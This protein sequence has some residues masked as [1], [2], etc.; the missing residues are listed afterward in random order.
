MSLIKSMCPVCRRQIMVVAELSGSRV[1]CPGCSEALLVTPSGVRAVSSA[2]KQPTLSTNTVADREKSPSSGMRKPEKFQRVTTDAVTPP[3]IPS[4]PPGMLKLSWILGAGVGA[5]GFLTIAL[6]AGFIL[7]SP[8]PRQ[9][10]GNNVLPILIDIPPTVTTKKPIERPTPTKRKNSL[11]PVKDAI[12]SVAVVETGHGHGSGFMAA[13]GL[14]VTNYHVISMARMEDVRIRFPDNSSVIEREFLAELIAEDPFNDIAVLRVDCEVPPLRIEEK[15]QHV[16]GQKVVA[17][18]SP[19]TGTTD[20]GMLANLTTDGRMG[21]EYPLPNGGIR[22][23]VSMAM[24]PGNSGGP[25]IDASHGE[26]VG[27]TV[28]M[29]TKTNSQSLAVPHPELIKI[30]RKSKTALK[31]DLQQALTLH[32]ARFCVTHMADLLQLTALSFHRSCKAARTAEQQTDEGMLAAFNDFK[33][34]ASRIFSDNF[35][36]FETDIAAEVG[37]LRDDV[38]CDMSVRLAL[39]KLHAIIEKQIAE[40]RKS[41]SIHDINDFLREF[42]E[43]LDHSQSLAQSISKSLSLEINEDSRE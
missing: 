9:T 21:P 15:F 8:G 14:L 4:S 42:E 28:A 18:G 13:S 33:S 41:V 3:P 19:G 30:L 22:W 26:V 29:F 11:D 25:I 37:F 24:N 16:N 20:G 10:K 32:R 17:I 7:I 36:R 39:G 27:V 1:H 31:T 2:Q 43:T 12:S 35:I 5:F 38:A 23:A 6:I 40:L 34:N